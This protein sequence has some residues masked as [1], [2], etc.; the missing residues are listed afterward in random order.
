MQRRRVLEGMAAGSAALALAGRSD[1]DESPE[2][3]VIV[4]KGVP[5]GGLDRAELAA[6][7]TV[8]RRTWPNGGSV[9]PLNAPIGSI[10]R[11]AFDHIVLGLQPNEVGQFWIDQRIRGQARPPRQIAEPRLLLRLVAQLAGAIGYVPPAIVDLS[12]RVVAR[13]RGGKLLPP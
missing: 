10:P 13:V 8:S 12:V 7:F 2:L 3:A 5:G 6:I 9:V 11:K 1:A 4:H